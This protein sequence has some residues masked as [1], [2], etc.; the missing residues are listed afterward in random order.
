MKIGI[1]GTGNVGSILGTRWTRK[2]HQV[3]FGSRD[4]NSTK[5]R[6]VLSGAGPNASAASPKEA[7][8]AADVVVLATP[9]D[10]AQDAIDSTG[11]LTGKILIDCT[12]PLKPD[13]TGLAIGHSTSAA[14]TVAGWA[15][16]ARVVKAFNT[17]GAGN[18]ANPIYDGQKA[19]MFICSNDTEARSVVAELAKDLD[20]DVVDCGPLTAARYL[21]PLA[22]LWIHLAFSQG[23]GREIAFK[24]LKR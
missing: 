6:K 8:A 16:G 12:N 22:M 18:M 1:L 23:L 24:L 20:F 15:K 11:D 14:E 4:P 17:T 7:V 21:E 2:G 19:S 13:L 9:W 3:V 10:A 5:V